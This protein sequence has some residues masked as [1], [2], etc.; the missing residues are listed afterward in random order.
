MEDEG[1]RNSRELHSSNAF[2]VPFSQ[3]TSEWKS[4]PTENQNNSNTSSL[5]LMS[6]LMCFAK[7]FPLVKGYI[8]R[9]ATGCCVSV[10]FLC[11]PTHDHHD[12][13]FLG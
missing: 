2:I 6:T 4:G 12:T 7:G 11:P 10:R 8:R 3:T 1:R 13:G 9:D 5:L